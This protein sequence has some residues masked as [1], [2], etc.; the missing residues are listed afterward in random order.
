MCHS[1]C[2]G[3]RTDCGNRFSVSFLQISRRQGI[4]GKCLDQVSHLTPHLHL[5]PGSYKMFKAIAGPKGRGRVG[6]Y[7]SSSLVTLPPAV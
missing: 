2:G 5:S 3:Q 7:L 6:T 1:A 4:G